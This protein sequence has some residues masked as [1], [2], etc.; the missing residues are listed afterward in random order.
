MLFFLRHCNFHKIL[1]ILICF[2]LIENVFSNDILLYSK[3]PSE[4]ASIAELVLESFKQGYPKEISEIGYD[5]NVSDWFLIVNNKKFYWAAGRFLPLKYSKQIKKWRPYVDYKY[6]FE[7]P[8]PKNFTKDDIEKIRIVTNSEN[9]ELEPPYHLD[10]FDALYDGKTRRKIES[11]IIN[12][13]FLGKNVN[14]HEK[15][16]D[17][18]FLIEN[19]IY[20]LAKIDEEIKTFLTH[21]QSIEGYNWREIADSQ[22][23]SYHSWGIALD[24]L[25][26]GWSKKNLYWNW[27]R[28]WNKDW[29]LIPLEKRWT[30]PEIVIN[31]FEKYGFIY[32]GKWI[33]WDNM[34]FE[35]RPELILLRDWEK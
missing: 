14:V 10:F 33:M 12:T 17:K 27:I 25:P 22:S 8:N 31:I 32:G 23:R 4:T 3:E 9:R 19:E 26:K 18:L 24:I 20:E 35:Y 13:K 30:P 2:F 1:N 34:H 28:S 7:I 11:H 21:L 6:P 15:I 29:M 16:V 5:R